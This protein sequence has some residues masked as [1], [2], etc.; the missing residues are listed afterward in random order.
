MKRYRHYLRYFILGFVVAAL[1]LGSVAI[2]ATHPATPT[3]QCEPF[4][5]GKCNPSQTENCNPYYHPILRDCDVN[6]YQHPIYIPP[7][8]KTRLPC[9]R[10]EG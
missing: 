9:P 3:E 5:T 10:Q 4:S 6:D 7:C 8:P 1:A 2:K